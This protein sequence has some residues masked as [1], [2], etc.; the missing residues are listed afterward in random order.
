[1]IVLV[2]LRVLLRGFPCFHDF[3]HGASLHPYSFIFALVPHI[4]H[5]SRINAATRMRT[6]VAHAA[7]AAPLSRV[8]LLTLGAHAQKGYGHVMSCLCVFV[9]LLPLSRQHRS[10]LRSKYGTYGTRLGFP[11]FLKRGISRK[12]SVGKLCREKANMQ[13]SSYRSRLVLARFEYRAYISRYLQ[14]AH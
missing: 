11:S 5:G 12:P 10:F 14:A 4:F 8:S 13:M 6:C 7:P 2:S 9:C 1:M 3:S